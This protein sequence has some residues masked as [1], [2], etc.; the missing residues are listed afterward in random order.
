MAKV[1]NE[2]KLIDATAI[3]DKLDAVDNLNLASEAIVKVARTVI[4][5]GDGKFAFELTG[6][7]DFMH[8]FNQQQQA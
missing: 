8:T 2:S 6:R 7:A 1:S 4:D 5:A 3:C